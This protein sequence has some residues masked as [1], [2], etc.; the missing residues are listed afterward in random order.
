MGQDIE[1]NRGLPNP[2]VSHHQKIGGLRE[3]SLEGKET[4]EQSSS[5]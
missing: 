1:T 3:T 2:R 5:C 4:I